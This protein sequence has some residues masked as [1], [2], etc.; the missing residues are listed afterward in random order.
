MYFLH[1][2]RLL[3]LPFFLIGIT[4]VSAQSSSKLFSL[5]RLYKAPELVGL[6]SWINSRPIDSIGELKGRVVL[7][8]FWTYSC[9]NC[10]NTIPHIKDWYKKYKQEGFIVLGIHTPEFKF[11]YE[12]SNVK[13]A[14][15]KHGITFPVALDNEFKLWRAFHN[16]YWPALYLIDKHGVVRYTHFGEGRYRETE[17]AIVSLLRQ[18]I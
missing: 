16:R 13:N 4:Q 5:P 6:T 1:Y 18:E 11:E 17:A 9:H 7:I 15:E 10:V 14:V 8:D 3:W 12:L 2:R